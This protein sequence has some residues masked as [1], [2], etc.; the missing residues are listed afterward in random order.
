ME[1]VSNDTNGVYIY[2]RCVRG[3]P[4]DALHY[5]LASSN[6]NT[7]NR[8]CNFYRSMALDVF[9]MWHTHIIA[10]RSYKELVVVYD[11]LNVRYFF[12]IFARMKNFMFAFHVERHLHLW[13]ILLSCFNQSC[14]EYILSVSSDSLE[15]REPSG[16]KSISML[17]LS[18]L[19][20]SMY[21]KVHNIIHL[22]II[23][24]AQYKYLF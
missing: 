22:I 14:D 6:D 15:C 2:K 11:C 17:E 16:M 21:M 10:D 13:S 1:S 3:H 7:K 18:K 20:V 12:Y 4:P 5:M 19:W 24:C 8:I 9:F 23:S